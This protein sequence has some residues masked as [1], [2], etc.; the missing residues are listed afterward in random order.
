MVS[1]E[2]VTEI[3]VIPHNIRASS[4]GMFTDTG[5]QSVSIANADDEH[6]IAGTFCVNIPGEFL[7][8][9]MIYGNVTDRCHPSVKFPESFHIAHSQSP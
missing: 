2:F 8:V 9:Q 4:G 5:S 6:Q 1:R 7:R 3:K